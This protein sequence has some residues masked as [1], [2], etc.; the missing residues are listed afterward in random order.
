MQREFALK[1]IPGDPLFQLLE[2]VREVVPDVLSGRVS[3]PHPNVDCHSGV[4][5][6]ALGMRQEK[7]YTVLFGVSRSLGIAAQFVWARAL[8]LPI[9]RPKSVTLRCL[10]ELCHNTAG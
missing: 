1:H 8:G 4:L 3:N 10:E 2:V 7:F 9:E 6:Q 5:L